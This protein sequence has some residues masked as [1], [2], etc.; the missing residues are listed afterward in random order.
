MIDIHSHILYGIDDGPQDIE[1]SIELLKQAISVGY[2]GVV[3]SSHYY[4]DR[5][6]NRNYDEN[7]LTLKNRIQEENLK[8]E[9]YKGNEF[10]LLPGYSQHKDRINTINNGKYFLFELKNELLYEICKDFCKELLDQ[11]I[12]P[13]LAHVERYP[14]IST[15]ELIELSEMGVALQ[16][17][18]RM[19]ANPVDRIDYLLRNR[20]IDVLATDT[21][22]LGKRDYNIS[23]TLAT[24]KA[25]LGEEYFNIVTKQNPKNIVNSKKLEKVRGERDEFKKTNGTRSFFSSLWSKL[26]RG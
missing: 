20:Y 9:I 12:V 21:H 3:C 26:C 2:T 8:I 10:A 1:E 11:G 23:D 19:A 17:N 22:R 18:L 25:R 16:V 15:G 24:I 5:F 6:E 4:I 14:H 7:F 13:V